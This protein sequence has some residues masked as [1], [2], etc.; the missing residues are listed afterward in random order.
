MRH[1]RL[2]DYSPQ[3]THIAPP[4]RLKASFVLV[5]LPHLSV[6]VNCFSFESVLFEGGLTK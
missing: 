6:Q 2:V 5:P 4:A 3:A 1:D